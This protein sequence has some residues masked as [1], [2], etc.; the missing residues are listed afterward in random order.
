MLDTTIRT[1][2]TRQL[3]RVLAAVIAI[4]TLFGLGGHGSA[5]PG[6]TIVSSETVVHGS[7]RVVDGD[8]IDVAGTR[9]RLEGIDAP[10]AGQTCGRADGQT[11]S[12]GWAA[13]RTLERLVG[14]GQVR[15]A[16]KGN[17][18]HGRM[19]GQCWSA[20]NRELNAEMVRLGLAW[21]FVRFSREYV[22]LETAARAAKVGVWQGASQP[23]WE[24]RA[25]TMR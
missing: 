1:Y 5:R 14:A 16:S 9:I 19:L 13:T 17:D 21:A 20:D 15:C 23:A 8:T 3:G 2:A 12:C 18:R 22:A 24:Y 11:W 7:A 6:S 25:H 10:E 4:A